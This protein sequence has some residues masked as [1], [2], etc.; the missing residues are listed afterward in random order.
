MTEGSEVTHRHTQTHTRQPG[1]LEG[2]GGAAAD[3][4]GGTR[5][6]KMGKEMAVSLET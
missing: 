1:T 3:V 4:S 2:C 5:T 6:E